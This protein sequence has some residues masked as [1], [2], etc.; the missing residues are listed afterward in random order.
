MSAENKQVIRRFVEEGLNPKNLAVL[1]ELVAD[2]RL[3]QAAGTIR[4]AFPDVHFTIEELLADEDKV[5]ARLTIRGTH[6][7]TFLGVAPTGK[8]ITV[9]GIAI[10]QIAGGKIV[11]SWLQRDDLGILQQLG[12]VPVAAR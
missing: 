11:A 2:E 10:Y 8:T 4:A 1:G 3:K 7:G 6:Q 12:A 9:T 5:I